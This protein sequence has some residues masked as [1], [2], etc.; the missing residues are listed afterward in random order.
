MPT[1][2]TNA[3][4][5]NLRGPT[6]DRYKTTVSGSP[7]NAWISAATWRLVDERVSAR[8]D[9]AKDQT[10]IRRLGRAIRASLATDRRRLAEKA[11]R[12]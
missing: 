6:E 11:G 7:E 4:G 2:R 9:L 8:Q 10:L 5:Y 1:K 3:V 12:R